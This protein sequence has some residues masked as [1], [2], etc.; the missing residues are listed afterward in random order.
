MP[1]G[2]NTY[3]KE[4]KVNLFTFLKL[5]TNIKKRGTRKSDYSVS[6]ALPWCPC[7][8]FYQREKAAR[9]GKRAKGPEW[10]RGNFGFLTLPVDECYFANKTQ[11]KA[12]LMEGN[13]QWKRKNTI[14]PVCGE[15]SRYPRLAWR[16][17]GNHLLHAVV[18]EGQAGVLVTDKGA[19]LNEADEYLGLGKLG[20]ELLVGSV[21]AFEEP[22]RTQ[23]RDCGVTFVI[24]LKSTFPQ[25]N[26]VSL[27][28]YPSSK[29]NV[30]QWRQKC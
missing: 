1:L 29:T 3:H 9:R 13:L 19:L 27:Y 11:H 25:S 21:S 6:P 4:K 22:L 7:R 5:V 20:V 8:W 24:R 26:Q 10:I 2:G 15:Y 12:P 30:R 18:K 17:A 16:W 14:K 23:R 28:F